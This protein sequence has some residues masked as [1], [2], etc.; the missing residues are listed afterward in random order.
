[1]QHDIAHEAFGVAFWADRNV[2]ALGLF[3]HALVS[4]TYNVAEK[5]TTMSRNGLNLHDTIHKAAPPSMHMPV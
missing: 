3:R 1:M 4:C 2:E 5:Y